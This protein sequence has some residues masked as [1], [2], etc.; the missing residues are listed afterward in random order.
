MVVVSV[1]VAVA[2]VTGATAFGW[3]ATGFW[4]SGVLLGA[5]TASVAFGLMVPLALISADVGS[6]R[7]AERSSRTAQKERRFIAAAHARLRLRVLRWKRK[8]R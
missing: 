8:P 3:W 1:V 4:F 5:F 6:V 7:Q 2:W